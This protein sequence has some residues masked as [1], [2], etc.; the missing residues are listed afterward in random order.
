L[1]AAVAGLPRL[2][3][4]ETTTGA[5]ATLAALGQRG[6]GASS[7]TSLRLGGK[8]AMRLTDGGLAALGPANAAA[9]RA[10][11][12]SCAG[13]A[14]P[15][16]AR[17][18]RLTTLALRG[19][20]AIDDAGVALLASSLRHLAALDL[21]HCRIG[22]AA[23]SALAGE[24]AGPPATLRALRLEGTACS[25]AA[26]LALAALPALTDL[27]VDA[28]NEAAGGG[29]LLTA[30]GLRLAWAGRGGARLTRLAV[31]GVA[32]PAPLIAALP[33]A[34]PH[35]ADLAIVDWGGAL[36]FAPGT[37]RP[38]PPAPAPP[39]RV[40]LAPLAG[41]AR[42]TTLYLA[43]PRVTGADAAALAAALCPRRLESLVLAAP[44][45]STACISALEA[46]W[47]GLDV[48]RA[49]RRAPDEWTAVGGGVWA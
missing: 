25:P 39:P 24:S 2:A 18:S 23:V 20:P 32:V 4:L 44:R 5:D 11:C 8:G 37:G 41:L 14:A 17:F 1:A 12:L 27:G 48:G 30:A 22:D 43:S 26:A 21:R 45:V 16:L 38:L 35:L 28:Y 9:L 49:R 31:R 13:V 15:A 36:A 19:C 29:G 47:P 46:E 10:L 33:A 3:A 34:C 40:C 7:L 42:L 6:G